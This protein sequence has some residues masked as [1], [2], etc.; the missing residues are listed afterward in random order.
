MQGGVLDENISASFV[1]LPLR[2]I[3]RQ[4]ENLL[5]PLCPTAN[6]ERVAYLVPGTWLGSV[7]QPALDNGSRIYTMSS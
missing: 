1:T 4:E 5:G 7:S 6:I 3:L 2:S